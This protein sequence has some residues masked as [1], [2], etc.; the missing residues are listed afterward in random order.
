MTTKTKMPSTIS[1]KK[2]PSKIVNDALTLTTW[3]RTGAGRS[4]L[5]SLIASAP[6]ILAPL[7]SITTFIALHTYNGSLSSYLA[8]VADEGFWTIS[9]KHGPQLTTEGIGAVAVWVAFQ[10][11]L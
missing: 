6:V 11:L 7:A 3:G 8:A 10:A 1:P 2:I 5:G 4:W 9:L